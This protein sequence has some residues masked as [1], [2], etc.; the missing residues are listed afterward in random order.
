MLTAECISAFWTINHQLSTINF[1][2]NRQ[3]SG[4]AGFQ[5]KVKMLD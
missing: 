3:D 5:Y 2:E 1:G 4:H